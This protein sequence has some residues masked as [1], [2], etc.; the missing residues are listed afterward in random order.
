MK[1]LTVIIIAVFLISGCGKKPTGDARAFAKGYFKDKVSAAPGFSKG[2][3]PTAEVVAT[4][5][6]KD[7]GRRETKE[8]NF[9]DET[10]GTL[11]TKAWESLNKKDEKGVLLFT[12]KCIELYADEAKGQNVG[13]TQYPNKGIIDAYGVLNAI[14]TCYFIRGEFFKYKKDWEK[15]KEVYQIL[16]DEY[17]F[18]QCWDPR[19]WYWQPSKIAKDEIRKINE[20]YYEQ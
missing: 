20:G 3:S 2:V 8:Y 19:G 12:D 6:I 16:I 4:Q 7:F 11:T 10:V 18:S 17:T 1:Y 5:E 13:L 15:S 14:G 9:G